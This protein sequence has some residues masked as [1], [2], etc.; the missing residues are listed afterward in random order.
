MSVL[1]EKMMYYMNH[2]IAP[3]A[4][5][6]ENQPHI[7][8]VRDGFIVVL[9]F[10]VVGSFIMI[11]LIPPFAE[12]TQNWFGKSWWAFAKWASDYG[13]RFF[14]M[15]FNLISLFTAGSIAYNLAKAYQREP[16]PAAFLSIMAFMLISMPV[17]DEK[18]DVKF[19]G[20]VGLFTA[21]FTAIYTV[22]L[23]RFLERKNIRIHLPKEVP[24]AVAESLNIVIPILAICL[25]LYPAALLIE[26]F[27]GNIIPQII[28][29]FMAPLIKA[30]DSIW[31]IILFVFA[32]HL[33]WFFGI[34]GSLVLMQLW[35][36][37]L[38]QNMGANLEALKAGEALPFI[39]TNSFWDF[40]VVHGA[41]GGVIA[42]AILLVRS[43]SMHLKSIGRIGLIPSIF[44]IGEPIV[45]GVPM[46]VNPTFFIPLIFAP[47]VNAVIAYLILDM[48]LIHRI[49]LMAPW[50]TPAPFGAYLVSGGDIWAPILSAG[51]IALDVLIYYPFFKSYE[52]QCLIREQAQSNSLDAIQQEESS[53]IHKDLMLEKKAEQFAQ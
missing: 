10:L 50:T 38:L 34:N 48:D 39:I 43:K 51:L 35:T 40:Y 1:S 28:L 7:V 47:I 24:H 21:I 36:P 33:L 29:D 52:K 27:T 3:L 9:P 12:D 14:Q 46:V 18:M 20:G 25:T 5:R 13:W 53:S 44:S 19:F 41:S 16:L 15:S 2:H 31:T 37:F 11:F 30:S 49:Y 26:Y 6:M 8:A 42:L 45:Y 22:E 32:T 23:T 17:V 4:K